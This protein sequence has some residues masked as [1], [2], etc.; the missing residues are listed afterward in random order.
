V[1]VGRGAVEATPTDVH[2]YRF[3][4][5]FFRVEIYTWRASPQVNV[6]CD[7]DSLADDADIDDTAA[8]DMR[9]RKGRIS[10]PHTRSGAEGGEGW[11]ATMYLELKRWR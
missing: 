2:C 1:A 10:T 8:A 9:W 7:A 5:S 6:T 11:H 3:V 4:V